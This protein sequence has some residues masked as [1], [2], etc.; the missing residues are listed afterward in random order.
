MCLKLD[1]CYLARCDKIHRVC[2]C[3]LRGEIPAGMLARWSFAVPAA[4][5]P[6]QCI[7]T[8]FESHK[9]IEGREDE[10]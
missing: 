2:Q 1:N 4:D 5:S 7:V 8:N 9:A 10:D 3:L 6:V